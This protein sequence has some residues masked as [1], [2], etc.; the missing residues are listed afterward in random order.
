[1][2][3][4]E[5]LRAD[6]RRQAA[7]AGVGAIDLPATA[8]ELPGMVAVDRQAIVAE[9]LERVATQSST[10][11]HA[12]LSQEIATLVPAGAAAS[13][14]ELVELVDEL[15]ATAAEGCVELQPEVPAGVARR[16]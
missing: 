8:P 14:T 15:T 16:C 1:M 13:A 11:L 4:A 12:D 2:G 10:W 6:W 9:A 7:E 5:A 3:E